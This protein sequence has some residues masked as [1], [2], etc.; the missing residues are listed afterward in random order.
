MLTYDLMWPVGSIW[1]K[2]CQW[3]VKLPLFILPRAGSGPDSGSLYHRE[4]TY[5]GHGSKEQLEHSCQTI[6]F[7]TVEFKCHSLFNFHY[8]LAAGCRPMILF[9]HCTFD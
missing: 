1:E 5:K 7:L 3:R 6:A 8:S 4:V 9:V 2:N